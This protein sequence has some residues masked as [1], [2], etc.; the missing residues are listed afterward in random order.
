MKRIIPILILLIFLTG[1]GITGRVVEEIEDQKTQED[2]DLDKINLALAEKDV[3]I[4][5]PI[6]TQP[7]REQCFI[8]L[9]KELQDP[10][11]CKNLIGSL[12]TTCNSVIN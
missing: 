12:R 3:S 8:L 1:C 9:A 6:E 5:Y 7:V 10:S 2:Q 11:I 4:C